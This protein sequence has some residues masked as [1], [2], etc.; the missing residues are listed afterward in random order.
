ML[1]WISSLQQTNWDKW[2]YLAAMAYQ[3][4]PH[5]TTGFSP[6]WLLYNQNPQYL[7]EPGEEV[8]KVGGTYKETLEIKMQQLLRFYEDAWAGN[9]RSKT[10][11]YKKWEGGPQVQ[12]KLK[13][14]NVVLYNN[15]RR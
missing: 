15:S 10:R 14:G 2:V 3:T 13:V 5:S 11:M 8:V 6:F 4:V 7:G 9:I 12:D 1:A